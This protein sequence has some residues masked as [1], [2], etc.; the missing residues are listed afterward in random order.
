MLSS[1]LKGAALYFCSFCLAKDIVEFGPLLCTK[2]T[3]MHTKYILSYVS[4]VVFEVF[5]KYVTSPL[6]EPKDCT[7]VGG[8]GG[9]L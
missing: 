6:A 9:L 4:A 3:R 1:Y 7:P 2:E 8:G 5:D